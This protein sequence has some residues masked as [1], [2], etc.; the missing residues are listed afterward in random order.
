MTAERP[1]MQR[2]FDQWL[3]TSAD[4]RQYLWAHR[5]KDIGLAR[6]MIDIIPPAAI[7]EFLGYLVEDY[8]GRYTGWPD[9]LVHRDD[10][11]FFAEVK[12]AG[13]TLGETQQRWIRDNQQRLHMPFK[14]VEVLKHS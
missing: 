1:E 3:G 6:H 12:S 10:E 5:N 7:I 13:D 9:L 11:F 8:W 2:L 14:I 4:L